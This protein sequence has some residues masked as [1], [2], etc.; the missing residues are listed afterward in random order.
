[1]KTKFV[2]DIS[3]ASLRHIIMKLIEA[4]VMF[5]YSL[6]RFDLIWLCLCVLSVVL[7]LCMCVHQQQV[8]FGFDLI[9]FGFGY[10][11]GLGRMHFPDPQW[12]IA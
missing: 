12:G 10:P 1:M 9:S 3:C 7:N 2:N 6:T 4:S 11:C 5:I 8:A